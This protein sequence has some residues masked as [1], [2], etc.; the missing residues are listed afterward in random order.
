M[1]LKLSM[2]SANY[3]LTGLIVAQFHKPRFSPSPGN[4]SPHSLAMKQNLSEL[5]IVSPLAFLLTLENGQVIETV[6]DQR[7]I[8]ACYP[9]AAA[10]IRRRSKFKVRKFW[11]KVMRPPA[12][13]RSGGG[14]GRFRGAGLHVELL[15]PGPTKA[16]C[17]L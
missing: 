4:S 12:P 2:L 17:G 6:G 16:R 11:R 7:H 14:R 13:V 15:I 8:L 1:R 5:T 10:G 9:V 3:D